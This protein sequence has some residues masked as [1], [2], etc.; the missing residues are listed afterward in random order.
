MERP[1]GSAPVEFRERLFRYMGWEDDVVLYDQDL[2]T[3]NDGEGQS[4]PKARGCNDCGIVAQ[5]L[6]LPSLANGDTLSD[7][8]P[9]VCADCYP[10]AA[11]LNPPKVARP[12]A[13]YLADER[14]LQPV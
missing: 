11:K 4:G 2:S 10:S 9:C 13:L 6:F 1:I 3:P 7:E 5:S 8:V 12:V 14:I